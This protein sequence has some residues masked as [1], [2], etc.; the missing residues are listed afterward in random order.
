MVLVQK[1]YLL[2]KNIFKGFLMSVINV[3]YNNYLKK[4]KKKKKKKKKKNPFFPL[5]VIMKWFVNWQRHPK[6][7]FYDYSLL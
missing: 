2:N 4:R 7:E 6:G 1:K 5:E 3:A